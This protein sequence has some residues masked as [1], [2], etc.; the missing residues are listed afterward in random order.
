VPG[1]LPQLSPRQ[2]GDVWEPPAQVRFR[3]EV[4]AKW[5]AGQFTRV[6]HTNDCTTHSVD[7]VPFPP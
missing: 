2:P 3:T 1:G 5:K 7:S 4:P 6:V